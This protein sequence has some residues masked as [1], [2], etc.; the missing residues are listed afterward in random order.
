[1]MSVKPWNP[2]IESVNH[3]GRNSE[4]TKLE[5]YLRYLKDKAM[6][7]SKR[8]NVEIAL[9]D[10]RKSHVLGQLKLYDCEREMRLEDRDWG[11]SPMFRI[12][13]KEGSPALPP[14]PWSHTQEEL[15][16]ILAALHA[17][18]KMEPMSLELDCPHIVRALKL[19]ARVSLGRRSPI[20]HPVMGMTRANILA[21]AKDKV[22]SK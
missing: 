2:Y 7:V 6:Y 20:C 22:E 16:R 18:D 19:Y 15:D 5:H 12:L 9:Q 8:L 21:I 4:L 13:C 10:R 1:M 11:W 3:D 14:R 17:D